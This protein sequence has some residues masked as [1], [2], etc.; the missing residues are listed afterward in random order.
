MVGKTCVL[1]IQTPLKVRV[2]KFN[3]MP[4]KTADEDLKAIMG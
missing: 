3:I 1:R 2:E 4:I